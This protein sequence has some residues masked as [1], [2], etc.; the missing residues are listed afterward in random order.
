MHSANSLANVQYWNMY[1]LI[2]DDPRR[3]PL[4]L[5][6]DIATKIIPDEEYDRLYLLSTG[7]II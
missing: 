2:H 1:Y 3:F 5:P 6:R 4:Y 7:I